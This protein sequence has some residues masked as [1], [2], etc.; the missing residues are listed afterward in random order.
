MFQIPTNVEFTRSLIVSG[1]VAQ[2]VQ[3]IQPNSTSHV[4]QQN[5]IEFKTFRY[6]F[7]GLGTPLWLLKAEAP[8]IYRQSAHEDGKVE[9]VLRSTKE[10][11]F[12]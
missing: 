1:T 3:Q 10:S 5:L 4:P 12:M 6:P 2:E 9:D 8:R 7:T 11:V